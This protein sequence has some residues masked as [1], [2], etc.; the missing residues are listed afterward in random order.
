MKIKTDADREQLSLKLKDELGVD[1]QK[2]ADDE[3]VENVVDLLIFPKYIINWAIRPVL[4][5]FALWIIGFFVVDLVHIEYIIYGTLGLFLFLLNGVLFGLVFL[6][7][8]LKRDIWGIVEYILKVMKNAVFDINQVSG[9]MGEGNRK[10]VLGLLFAG[11]VHV[12]YVPMLSGIVAEKLPLIGRFVNGIIRRTFSLIVNKAD[13]EDDLVEEAPMEL[14]ENNKTLS[15]YA[16]SI[17][18]ASNG[19]NSLLGISFKV[20][21]YPFQFAFGFSFLLLALFLYLIW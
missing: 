7:W 3:V 14:V 1:L 2:Y 15:A 13:F 4:V 21:R 11:F 12:V 19:L 8:K 16:S 10:E 5:A 20:V 9:Q 17:D 6:S 18:N